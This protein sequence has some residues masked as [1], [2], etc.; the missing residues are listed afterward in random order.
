MVAQEGLAD[1]SASGAVRHPLGDRRGAAEAAVADWYSATQSAK[2]LR[3]KSG[4]S[5][6]EKTYSL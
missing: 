6:G 1:D 2:T 5:T 3:S 4:H